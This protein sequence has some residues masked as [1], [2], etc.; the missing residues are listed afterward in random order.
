MVG[1]DAEVLDP[2]EDERGGLSSW[3]FF[4]FSV[5]IRSVF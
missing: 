3:D 5:I 4:S 1:R 2:G